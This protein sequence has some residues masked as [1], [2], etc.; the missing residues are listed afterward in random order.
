MKLPGNI[1]V[2]YRTDV[3]SCNQRSL[4]HQFNPLRDDGLT[5]QEQIHV[6]QVT[7]DKGIGTCMVKDGNPSLQF[8]FPDVPDP[9]HKGGFLLVNYQNL[10]T[11]YTL[12]GIENK[13]LGIVMFSSGDIEGISYRPDKGEL[14]GC[15][16]IIFIDEF[17]QTEKYNE[18]LPLH[19]A[20]V[21]LF[22]NTF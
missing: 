16:H 1:A 15:H 17:N 19:Q 13:M 12:V 14:F 10:F 22:G 9:L 4:L 7:E 18:F 20:P 21:N 2:I 8:L 5:V 3:A 6:S 11:P